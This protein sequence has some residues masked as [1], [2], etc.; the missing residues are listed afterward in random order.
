MSRLFRVLRDLE[1]DGV[2][3]T[4]GSN[5]EVSKPA[6]PTDSLEPGYHRLKRKGEEIVVSTDDLIRRAQKGWDAEAKQQEAAELR[7]AVKRSDQIFADIRAARAG[8]KEAAERLATYTD[9]LGPVSAPAAKREPE[10]DN[11]SRDLDWED[12]PAE[13]RAELMASRKLRLDNVREKIRAD[14]NKVLDNDPVLSYVMKKKGPKAAERLRKRAFSNLERRAQEE[15]DY[16][17]SYLED[18]A[19]ELRAE[20]EDLGLYTPDALG[21]GFL[22]NTPG[23]GRSTLHRKEKLQRP[24]STNTNEY[25]RYLQDRVS[26]IEALGS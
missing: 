21:S 7:K 5:A 11:K 1:N 15:Q 20:L 18:T 8:D 3:D 24:S 14:L 2:Q 26:E 4:T 6:T 17:P 12:L 25:K 13:V 22:G 23:G 9:E 19:G 16:N 10:V